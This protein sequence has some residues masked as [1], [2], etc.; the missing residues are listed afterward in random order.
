MAHLHIVKQKLDVLM[1]QIITT[2]RSTYCNRIEDFCKH[3]TYFTHLFIL[4]QRIKTN[5][6]LIPFLTLT[7]KID[8]KNLFKSEIISSC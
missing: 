8:I 3:A 7:L 4:G 1:I 5:K 6:I 2:Y